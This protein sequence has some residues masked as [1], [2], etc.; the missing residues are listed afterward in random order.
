MPGEK[1]GLWFGVKLAT[2]SNS[3]ELHP[4]SRIAIHWKQSGK[5]LHIAEIT[6]SL[7]P[8]DH[9]EVLPT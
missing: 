6:V 7:S 5:E 2:A 4:K 9:Y 8:W 1:S 3:Q